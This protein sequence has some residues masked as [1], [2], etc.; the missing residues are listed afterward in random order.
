MAATTSTFL[1]AAQPL[2]LHSGAPASSSSSAAA[3]AIF[4]LRR[5]SLLPLFSTLSPPILPLEADDPNSSP[6]FPYG[7]SLRKG[8]RPPSPPIPEDESK[9]AAVAA[10][11]LDRESFTRVLLLAALRVPAELCAALE[12]RLR[13]HL[14]NWPRVRN[15][16]RVSGDDLDPAV[17]G[18]LRDRRGGGEDRLRPALRREEEEEEEDPSP[19]MLSPVLYREK[20]V[21]DFN[22]RGFLKFRNLAKLSRPRKRK[23]KTEDE[24]G[25]GSSSRRGKREFAVVEVVEDSGEGEEE[26]QEHWGRLLGNGF[27]AGGWPGPTRLLLLDERYADRGPEDLPEAIKAVMRADAT[28]GK[29]SEYQFVR[30][31]LTLSYDYWSTNEILE[32]LLPEGVVAP[33]AFETVGH[34][35]HLNLREEHF[36]FRKLIAQVILDKNRP[37]IQTVVNKTDAIQNDFRTMPLEVLAGNHSLVTTLLESGTRFQV[38]LAT[39]Y[40]NSRL[41]TE[42]QRLIGGFSGDDVLC[43]V[44][45]GAGPITVAAAKKVRRVYANDLNPEAVEYLQTNVALNKLQRKIEVFNMDGRR[46]IEAVFSREAAASA[47]ATQ[48]VMNLPKDAGRGGG[49]AAAADRRRA[50]PRIHVYGFSKSQDPEFD[51]RERIAVALGCELPLDVDVHRVRLVAPGKWML[52]GSFLLPPAVAFALR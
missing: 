3:A 38:N 35:A 40:W 26:E 21:K 48:V 23:K 41:A 4:P 43:D 33:S 42:R 47:A 9:A 45:A 36:P 29:P 27:A 25:E 49:A 28:P 18:L 52:C 44:F 5:S 14:L 16:A 20:L 13:G 12:G 17:A 32:G 34:I 15:V 22:H 10:P 39:V 24:A 1:R 19:E 11:L 50:L 37:K 2:L 8:L 6:P 7:P 30:C 31:R 51:F 46:F